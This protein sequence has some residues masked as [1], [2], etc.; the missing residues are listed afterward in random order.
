MHLDNPLSYFAT[1]LLTTTNFSILCCSLPF[2]TSQHASTIQ[3]NPL[4]M[5]KRN[6]PKLPNHFTKPLQSPRL[7]FRFP[8]HLA[9]VHAEIARTRCWMCKYLGHNCLCRPTSGDF[10]QLQAPASFQLPYES[11]R[12]NEIL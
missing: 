9:L 6:S 8:I 12:V 5:L 11:P 7:F 10:P 3:C 4:P 1:M 2:L